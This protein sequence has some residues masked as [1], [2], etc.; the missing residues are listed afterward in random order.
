[1]EW[2]F[3]FKFIGNLA[4]ERPALGHITIFRQIGNPQNLVPIHVNRARQRNSNQLART[5]P[6]GLI[7]LGITTARMK[8]GCEAS[9]QATCVQS[10]RLA[11]CWLPAKV[12]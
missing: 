7:S 8:F 2:T 4:H 9:S 6:L 1:M 12:G 3:N 5:L 11:E 10:Q